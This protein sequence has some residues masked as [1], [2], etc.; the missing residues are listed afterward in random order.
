ML[1]I[2]SGGALVWEDTG[3]NLRVQVDD[4]IIFSHAT[5]A[6]PEEQRWRVL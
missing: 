5:T 6:D 2:G 1:L 3:E 4:H